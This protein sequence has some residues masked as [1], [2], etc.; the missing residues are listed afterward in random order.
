M[1]C[2]RTCN[3]T[4]CG[5]GALPAAPTAQYVQAP[6]ATENHAQNNYY[7]DYAV[8]LRIE[9]AWNIPK[10]GASA[11]LSVPGTSV[12]P[13][14]AVLWHPT[15]GYFK[16]SG[17]DSDQRLLTLTNEGASGNLPPGT[18]VPACTVFTVSPPPCCTDDTSGVFVKLDFTAPAEDDCIDITL[19]ATT[20]LAAGN[21]AQIG[22]AI[23]RV[24]EIKANNIITICNDG[25]GFPAGTSIYSKNA[26]DNYQYPVTPLSVSDC[27][28]ANTTVGILKVCDGGIGKLLDGTDVGS[29]VSL[30]DAST[31]TVSFSNTI[32]LLAGNIPSILTNVATLQTDLTDLGTYVAGL[33]GFQAYDAADPLV[34]STTIKSGSITLT[35]NVA[36]VVV[37]NDSVR[38]QAFFYTIVGRIFG[39]TNLSNTNQCTIDC[40]LQINLNGAGYISTSVMD[41]TYWQRTD[42]NYKQDVQM[43]WSGISTRLPTEG[44]TLDARVVV[45]W[46]GFGSTEY[47]IDNIDVAIST[48]GVPLA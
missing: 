14:G 30:V 24:S 6:C 47:I 10:F 29:L 38:T 36:T 33:K 41:R 44:F 46:I 1:S 34:G 8:G 13:V 2:C 48:V 25:Q 27:N 21:N 31:N 5:C 11:V 12:V 23:Y 28:G 19:T 7:T 35:S 37:S 17:F 39:N 3:R 43:N 9:S 15:Y 42:D 26:A 4:P 40:D 16:I 45:T 18:Q 32:P 20:G 22:T